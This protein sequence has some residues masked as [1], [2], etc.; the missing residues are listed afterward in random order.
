MPSHV[1]RSLAT[2]TN[3]S[4]TSRITAPGGPMVVFGVWPWLGWHFL[5]R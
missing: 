4:A 2:W 5:A 1:R 3:A